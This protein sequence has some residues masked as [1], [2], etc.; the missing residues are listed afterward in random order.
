MRYFAII[1]YV[2]ENGIPT[3]VTTTAE[4]MDALHVK[5]RIACNGKDVLSVS[6]YAGQLVKTFNGIPDTI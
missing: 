6:Y 3:A 4:S 1:K 2:G 5:T